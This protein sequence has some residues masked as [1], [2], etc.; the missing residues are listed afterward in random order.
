MIAWMSY[1]A[2]VGGIVAVGGLALERLAAAAGRPRR[3]AW[4]AALALAVVIPLAGGWS[5]PAPPVVEAAVPQ[6]PATGEALAGDLRSAFPALPV[7]GGPATGRVAAL[8]WGAGSLAALAVMVGVL[9]L[10]ARGR[11]RWERTRVLGTDVYLSRRFG[12][13]LVGVARPAVVIPEWVVK[14]EP[15]ARDAIIRHENE[16]ARAGDHLVLLCGGLVAAAFPWSPAIWWMYRRLRAAVEL[17]CDQRVLASGIGVADYG[18]VL[19]DA[20]CRSRG[21]WGFSPAMGQPETL[22]ERRL[23]TMNQTGRKLSG[24]YAALLS[25]VAVGAL[26]AACD[27]PVPTEFREAVEEVI[28]DESLKGD[29]AGLRTSRPLVYLDGVRVPWWPEPGRGETGGFA[30]PLGKLRPEDIERIEVIKGP[31]AR[32]IYGEEAAFGVIQVFTK[33]AADDT[34]AVDGPSGKE[35]VVSGY[36]G[37]EPKIELV[38]ARGKR[39][40]IVVTNPESDEERF[41][42]EDLAVVSSVEN[43]VVTGQVRVMKRDSDWD[44]WLAEKAVRDAP[45]GSKPVIYID[46]VRVDGGAAL[47]AFHPALAAEN[48]ERIE[49]IK[50]EAAKEEY[51]EE[52]ANGVIRIITK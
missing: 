39:R 31:E 34:G 4:L 45:P 38:A 1:A 16:H 17:D 41:I 15:G 11:H 7:P 21:R 28:S 5:S 3:I 49:V 42:V 29:V 36:A 12:P 37:Q 20:G 40:G 27:T 22:L 47:I 43:L 52:G 46:G 48:I 24:L 6:P 9:V 25:A 30:D 2:L 50:G 19:L 18:D 10:V 44:R 51:G 8:V 13:A 23:R 26:A 33:G 32:E 35:I 14:L